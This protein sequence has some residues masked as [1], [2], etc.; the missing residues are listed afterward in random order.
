VA[1]RAGVTPEQIEQVARLFALDNKRGIATAGTGPSMSP[2]SNLADHLV[3]CLNV[4]CGRMYR[5]GEP[6][7]NPGV[8]NKRRAFRAE[9]VPAYREWE[10]G[11]KTGSGHGTLFGELMSGVLADEI[12]R[13][14][15]G[16]IR[17]LL[18]NGGNPA[19]AL[20]DQVKAV[21]ALQSLELMVAVEPFMTATARLCDYVLPPKLQFERCDTAVTP[22][23]E[24][25]IDIPFAQYVPAICTPPPDSDVADDWYFYWGIA[26]RLGCSISFAGTQLDMSTA[27]KTDEL[28]A[29]ALRHAQVPFE[30]IREYTG[31]NLFAVEP[32][33]VE[34]A[35]PGITTRFD[36][37]PD[38]VH[39]ELEAARAESDAAPEEKTY[40]LSVRRLR[41]TMNSLGLRL[42]E[43]RRRH[44]YNAAYIH[45]DDL[46]EMDLEDCTE[47]VISADCGE[48]FA[49]AAADASMRR[50]VISMSHCW[51]WLPDEDVPYTEMGASTNRLV[52]TDKFI[53]AIN[54]M[55]RMSSIP[56]RIKR[57]L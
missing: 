40:L 10:H 6:I 20:P 32:A 28:L 2:R 51:G 11:P 36:V 39:A 1:K 30:T 55:P 38:D 48:V 18:V 21:R 33:F 24:A 27:P 7:A 44:P 4:I 17:A 13:P 50:G 16:R 9:V 3:E 42:P 43:I 53:E 37:M 46:A 34:P 57:R 56:I 15:E 12:L 23:Y 25:M 45:P 8:Q 31:G 26:K 19:V 29:L 54:A 41:G 52:R 47:I 49:I 35:R 22:K 14:D 5:E